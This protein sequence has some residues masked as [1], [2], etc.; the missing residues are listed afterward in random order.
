MHGWI[1]AITQFIGVVSKSLKIEA[2][3][4]FGGRMIRL[5]SDDALSQFIGGR[6][7]VAK[8]GRDNWF[9]GRIIRS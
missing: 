1:N 4:D 5:N 6:L 3:I 2:I 7:K 9:G 8:N